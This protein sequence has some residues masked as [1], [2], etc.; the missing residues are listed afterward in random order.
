MK[1]NSDAAAVRP[2]GIRD[3]VGY[4]FGDHF[5]SDLPVRVCRYVLWL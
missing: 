3:K 1:T 4:M 2:F 5:V